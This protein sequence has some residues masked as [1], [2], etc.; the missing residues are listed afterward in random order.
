MKLTLTEKH[1]NA[2]LAVPWSSTT[3][4][5]AQAAKGAGLPDDCG[6]GN[7]YDSNSIH[8]YKVPDAKPLQALF[9]LGFSLSG[10]IVDAEAIQKLRQ[11]LPITVDVIPVK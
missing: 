7:L 4:I 8:R 5:L 1:L 10:E 9:D 3:C 2:A 11:L 6:Q